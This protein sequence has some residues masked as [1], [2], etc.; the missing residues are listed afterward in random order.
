MPLPPRRF[1]T[2]A[3]CPVSVS[4][5]ARMRAAR[6]PSPPGGTPTMILIGCDGASCAAAATT[7]M[8]AAKA[9][10][11]TIPISARPRALTILFA[12]YLLG[13]QILTHRPAGTTST[14]RI[15]HDV[16]ESAWAARDLGER[17]VDLGERIGIGLEL[18]QIKH[19]RASHLGHQP[20][21]PGREPVRPA[22]LQT[23]GH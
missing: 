18:A 6:S 5:C 20:S 15:D 17:A 4:R 13:F 12:P 10:A 19:A 11:R 23:G 1:S 16:D 21:L 7:A 22:Q 14:V 3:A 8:P 9:S 2:I